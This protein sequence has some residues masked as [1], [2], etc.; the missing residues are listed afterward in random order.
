MPKY[1]HKNF[2]YR[3]QDQYLKDL[4]AVLQKL[5][6]AKEKRFFLKDLLTRGERV[7]ITRRF[8]IAQLLWNGYTY[9]EIKELMQVG[10]STVSK[11][12]RALN[13]GRGGYL[14]AIKKA[15]TLKKR[16]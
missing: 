4:C 1:V 15:L 3:E 6:S 8:K 5:S 11:V 16:V 13:F 7:M 14:N 9:D 12:E 10:R 2:P